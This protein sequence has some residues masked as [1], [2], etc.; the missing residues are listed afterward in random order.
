MDE[1]QADAVLRFPSDS[2]ANFLLSTRENIQNPRSY[3]QMV[4]P[5]D[6]TLESKANV[7]NSEM[8]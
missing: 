1:F 8:V 5:F 4:T 2:K 3:S 6:S 7:Q